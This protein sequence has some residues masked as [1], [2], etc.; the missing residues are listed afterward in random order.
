MIHEQKPLSLVEVKKITESLEEKKDISD[1][2]KKFIK[3]DLKKAEEM[4]KEL[5]SLNNLKIKEE[6]IVK[7]IDLMPETA[8]EVNKIFTDVSLTEDQINKILEIVK[9]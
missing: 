9:K 2:L 1:Y 7:I 3:V 6:D 4:K 5:L 8:S